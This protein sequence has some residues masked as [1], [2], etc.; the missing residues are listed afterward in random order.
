MGTFALEHSLRNFLLELALKNFRLETLSW[1]LSFGGTSVWE[2]S[3]R[4]THLGFF[5]WGLR[6]GIFGL[7][8]LGDLWV[9]NWSPEVGEPRGQGS[10]GIRLGVRQPFVFKILNKNPLGKPS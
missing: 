4:I 2:L 9:G 10:G 3:L 6:L 7:E 5:A 1:E 8:S